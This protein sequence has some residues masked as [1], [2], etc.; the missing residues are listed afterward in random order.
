MKKYIYRRMQN[1]LE[2]SAPELPFIRS[3]MCSSNLACRTKKLTNYF[4]QRK[5]QLSP[6][7]RGAIHAAVALRASG[8][9]EPALPTLCLFSWKWLHGPIIVPTIYIHTILIALYSIYLSLSL[10][11]AKTQRWCMYRGRKEREGENQSSPRRRFSAA[12]TLHYREP[13]SVTISCSACSASRKAE[14]R[15]HTHI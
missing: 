15:T 2:W 8:A 4:L 1:W 13:N 9:L 5:N 11:L 3:K 10:P 7:Q 6:F 12:H 14:L